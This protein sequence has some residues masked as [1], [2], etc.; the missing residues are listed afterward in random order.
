MS[1]FRPLTAGYSVSP[2]ISLED[3]AAAKAAGYALVINNRPDGEDPAAPQGAD[4]AHA[5]AAE[6]LAY[7]AIPVGHAGFSHAQLDALDTL[8]G[9]A[10]GP[11][12]AYCR[13]GTRST[14]LWALARARA[15]DDL[16][17]IC[18]AASARGYDLSALRPM[19]DALAGTR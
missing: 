15:G 11:V 1:D 16:D 10:T 19:M 17:A 8:L 7:A 3:V 6:G 5:C 4:I 12:L 13:S 9:D 18:N 2:Q 14:H